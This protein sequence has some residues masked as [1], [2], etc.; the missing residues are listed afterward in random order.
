MLT[1]SAIVA[2]NEEER[3]EFLLKWLDHGGILEQEYV[4]GHGIGIELLYER[5]R[6]VWHFAHERIHELP[7]TGGA[8]SYRR[9]IAADPRLLAAAEKLLNELEWHGVAMVEFR[10]NRTD[11][12]WLMEINPRLWGSLALSLDAG[13]N[14]PLGLLRLARGEY[15][16]AQPAYR[17]HYYTRHL[18]NDLRWLKLN[19]RADARDVT[20]LTRPRVLSFLELLRPLLGRESWDHFDW[21]DLGVMRALLASVA[22]DTA[23]SLRAALQRRRYPAAIGRHH[24]RVLRGFE[25]ARQR[26]KRLLFLCHGNVCRSPFAARLVAARLTGTEVWAAGFHPTEGRRAPDHFLT[27]ARRAG[28]DLAGARSRS[29]NESD[30]SRADLIL[31]MDHT[32]HR[33]FARRFP[34]ALGRMTLL[35]LFKPSPS[36]EIADPYAAT[37][38]ETEGILRHLAESV[39]CLARWVESGR[40]PVIQAES[41]RPLRL[42]WIIE[43]DYRSGMWHGAN[44]RWFNLSRELLAGGH[45]VHFLVN[46]PPTE[47]AS[48]LRSY[49][50]GLVRDQVISGYSEMTFQPPSS[51]GRLAGICPWPPLTNILLRRSQAAVLPAVV[52]LVAARGVDACLLSERK[53]LFLL[54]ALKRYSRVMVDWGDSFVLYQRRQIRLLLG[55]HDLRGLWRSLRELTSAYCLE[56]YYGRRADANL[57][58]SPVDKRCL[59]AVNRLPGRN[60]VLLNGLR[61]PPQHPAVSKV[62][63][64]VVFSGNMNFPPNY[65]AAIYFIDTVL[66]LV[67]KARPDAHFVV[68]GRNPIAELSRRASGAVTI[69]GAVED[70]HAEIAKG[71]VYVAPLIS[72]GG[73]KNKILEAVASGT[74]VVASPT[75]VEFLDATFR[76]LLLVADSPRLMADHIAAVLEEPGRYAGRLESLQRQVYAD[77]TWERRADELVRLVRA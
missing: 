26:P 12:F 65:E 41:S 70:M 37:T 73:F 24:A 60:H 34:N 4:P 35:G 47:D 56:R 66:P 68:A 1:A 53:L 32:N 13:V 30:V 58:V 76:D 9:S 62:P 29:V 45:Q 75:A 39:D 5:G 19:R 55:R 44:L 2:R 10:V 61:R 64:R 51:R 74:F 49:L 54:P 38:R 46:H 59:D 48:A 23:K 18:P 21:R 43:L 72:G 33:A 42:L 57:V 11:D 67:R 40:R 50:N 20:L 31:L 69:L 25:K 63:N 7:L 14:F 8:S 16:G 15:P 52:E 3:E 28:V 36:V 27:A 77:F 71:A 17:C 6:K 22:R